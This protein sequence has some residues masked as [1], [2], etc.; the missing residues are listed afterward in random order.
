VELTLK[1]G[2]SLAERVEAVRGTAENPM[3]HDE[4]VS[5]CR[6]LIAPMLGTAQTGKLIDQVMALERVKN[7]REIGMLLERA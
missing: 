1:D 2:K 6:D 4:V 7:V 5:K 3:T